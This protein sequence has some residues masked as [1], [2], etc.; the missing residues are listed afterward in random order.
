M[1]PEDGRLCGPRLRAPFHE[2]Q[3]HGAV[4]VGVVPLGGVEHV[5]RQP[6]IARAGFDQIE[7]G[8]VR[9]GPARRRPVC[10][11]ASHI[12]ANWL[13]SSSPNSGPRST[14]VKKS[15]SRPDRWPHRA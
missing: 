3:P 11:S 9:S 1:R 8:R 10:V 2:V 7:P 5:A 6:A 12:S 4:E 13:A 14:L 15:P